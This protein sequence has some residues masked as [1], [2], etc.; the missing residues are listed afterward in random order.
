MITADQKNYSIQGGVMDSFKA[1]SCLASESEVKDFAE[2]LAIASDDVGLISG[3]AAYNLYSKLELSTKGLPALAVGV[4]QKVINA[5]REKCLRYPSVIK[6]PS[7]INPQESVSILLFMYLDEK[8]RALARDWIGGLGSSSKLFDDYSSKTRSTEDLLAFYGL[9][10]PLEAYLSAVGDPQLTL[11][12]VNNAY[13]GADVKAAKNKIHSRAYYITKEKITA[14]WRFMEDVRERACEALKTRTLTVKKRRNGQGKI[15]IEKTERYEASDSAAKMRVLINRMQHSNS[16]DLKKGIKGLTSLQAMHRGKRVRE[17]WLT[18][19][20]KQGKNEVLSVEDVAWLNAKKMHEQAKLEQDRFLTIFESA[21][22]GIECVHTVKSKTLQE[23]VEL[24]N[25]QKTFLHFL[26]S[27]LTLGIVAL[28]RHV[29]CHN[30]END[31]ENSSITLDL[32]VKYK[33]ECEKKLK[34]A[35]EF[36]EKTHTDVTLR[37]EELKA[38]HK[39]KRDAQRQKV[40]DQASSRPS[41]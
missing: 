34:E 15:V 14:Q 35:E 24:K 9:H 20:Y 7:L 10:K 12:D 11:D 40:I 5:C 33:D 41:L 36:V 2:L 22:K 3:R 8:I 16:D 4:S 31:I 29:I 23:V 32:A 17:A 38:M 37:Y 6:L 13:W 39:A 18:D 27:F 28:Y 1:S 25:T 26:L 21:K 19:A 30:L